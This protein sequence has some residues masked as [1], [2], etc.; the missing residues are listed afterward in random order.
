M[1]KQKQIPE[2]AWIHLSFLGNLW[3]IKSLESRLTLKISSRMTRSLGY[4]YPGT[5]TIRLNRT[6]LDPLNTKVFREVLCHEAAHVV[7]FLLYGSRCK[8]HGAQWKALMRA[9]QCKPRAKI[10]DTEIHGRL[11]DVQG[12]RYR[13]THRCLDCGSIYRSRRTDRRWRCKNCKSSGLNGFLELVE[14]KRI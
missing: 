14:R 8:P 12:K 10:P 7:V 3:G 2:F 6:L 11:P 1:S 13:Y 9:A 4:C 5:A